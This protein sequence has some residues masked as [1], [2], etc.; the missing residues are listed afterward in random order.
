MNAESMAL[1]LV[2]EIRDSWVHDTVYEFVVG[3]RDY[4]PDVSFDDTEALV[5]AVE[6]L[7]HDVEF[8]L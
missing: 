3:H 7:A 5:D 2:K 8:T 1:E 6:S 4:D